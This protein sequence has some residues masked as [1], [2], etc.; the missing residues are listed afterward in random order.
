M[1]ERIDDGFSTTIAFSAGTSG[2][3][4]LLWEKSLTPPGVSAGGATDTTTMR[5]T[6][7]RT[8]APKL[9]KTLT[10]AS[11]QAAYDPEVYDE[12]VAMIGVNQ[13]IVITFADDST[14]TFWG[15]I[16]A[17]T[18]GEIVEGEQPVADLTIIPTNQNGSLVETAPEYA[19]AV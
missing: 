14:F 11:V 2:V 12:L 15:F 17:F 1:S 18:P 16:D 4:L 7:W 9:L 19:D 13:S 8:M 5:N 6:T 3:T 10:E